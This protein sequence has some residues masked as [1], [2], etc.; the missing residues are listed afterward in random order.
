MC[1]CIF[2][3]HDTQQELSIYARIGI[4]GTAQFK[5]DRTRVWHRLDTTHFSFYM[6]ASM[7]VHERLMMSNVLFQ[8]LVYGLDVCTTVFRHT[9]ASQERT[10]KI[11]R[12]CKLQGKYSRIYCK[13]YEYVYVLRCDSLMIQNAN[14]TCVV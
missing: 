8:V 2:N 1:S 12:T 11:M 10:R 14:A 7:C 13:L 9:H 5:L 4:Y 6:H 3:T